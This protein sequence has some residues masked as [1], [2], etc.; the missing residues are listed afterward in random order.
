MQ[1]PY[2]NREDEPLDN[3]AFCRNYCTLSHSLRVASMRETRVIEPLPLRLHRAA[4]ILSRSND[5]GA[6][7]AQ[8]ALA[9]VAARIV[10]LEE[11]LAE[12]GRPLGRFAV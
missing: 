4:S 6:A 10:I 7:D 2:R 12:V 3:P 5:P 11:T 8:A 9:E 1:T